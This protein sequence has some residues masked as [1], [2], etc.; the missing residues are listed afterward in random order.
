VSTTCAVSHTAEVLWFYSILARI[1]VSGS[2]QAVGSEFALVHTA[3]LVLVLP[4][5]ILLSRPVALRSDWDE[6]DS[7]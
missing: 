2:G 3:S 1:I 6:G 5:T 7:L 4:K